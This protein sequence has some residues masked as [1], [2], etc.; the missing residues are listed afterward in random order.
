MLPELDDLKEIQSKSASEWSPMH[1]FRGGALVLC[2]VSNGLL[3]AFSA[4]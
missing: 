3:Y 2:Y 4:Q 1:T